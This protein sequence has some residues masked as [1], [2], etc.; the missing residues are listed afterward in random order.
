MP[1]KGLGT[2]V[3]RYTIE[4]GGRDEWEGEILGEGGWREE[5][6]GEGR[7][8]KEAEKP[9]EAR[10]RKKRLGSKPVPGGPRKPVPCSRPAF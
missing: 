8:R 4:G 5:L 6:E 10:K 2:T 7:R 1:L 3:F 9:S